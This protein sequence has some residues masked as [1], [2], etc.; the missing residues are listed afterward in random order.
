M[1]LF[2]FLLI[3]VRRLHRALALLVN[4]A[5]RSCW[6]FCRIAGLP[7][8]VCNATGDCAGFESV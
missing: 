4:L 3:L 7:L 6:A 2:M 5:V 1:A 8:P